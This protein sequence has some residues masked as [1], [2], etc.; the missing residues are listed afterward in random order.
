MT[1]CSTRSRPRN[2]SP[3][4]RSQ[5]SRCS[6]AETTQPRLP[7]P[8][9]RSTAAGPRSKENGVSA[10]PVQLSKFLS[11][12]LR[13]E[14]GAIGLLLDEQGWAGIDDLVAKADASGTRFSR[15]D[16]LNVVE[17]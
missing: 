14:P 4:S 16:L 10:D 12:V 11:F 2:S 1:C 8:T 5:R 15:A 3:P 7:A 17:T 9:C 6:C 13:H